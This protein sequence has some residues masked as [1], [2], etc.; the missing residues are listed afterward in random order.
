MN[1]RKNAPNHL[2]RRLILGCVL[3]VVSITSFS[4]LS[5]VLDCSP[6]K[7]WQT[8][9]PDSYRIVVEYV[10]PPVPPVTQ[11]IFVKDGAIIQNNILSCDHNSVLYSATLCDPIKTYYSQVGLYT[12]DKLLAD[13]ESCSAATEM[14]L[15][16]CSSSQVNRSDITIDDLITITKS[17]PLELDSSQSIC[18]TEYDTTY[19]YPEEINYFVPQI[20][21]GFGRIRITQFEEIRS[22]S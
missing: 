12:V 20:D 1:K 6:Y 21:D 22:D 14:I 15:A 4:I 16:Q 5:Y 9:G 13:A 11:E 7:L 10:W 2:G 3:I 8:N 19:G 18:I 17:C